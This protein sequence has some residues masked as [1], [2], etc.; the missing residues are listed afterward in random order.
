MIVII[1]NIFSE[2]INQKLW[3]KKY[4]L[5]IFLIHLFK[6]RSVVKQINSHHCSGN[7]QIKLQNQTHE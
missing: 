4:H 3:V 6:Q 1:I 2:Q 5:K 7:S